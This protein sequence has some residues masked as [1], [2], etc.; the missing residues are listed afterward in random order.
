MAA[1]RCF[2]A[3][4]QVVKEFCYET[5]CEIYEGCSLRRQHY[6]V[7][8]SIALY[9]ATFYFTGACVKGYCW[10]ECRK[11]SILRAG[12]NNYYGQRFG[13]A[14][15]RWDTSVHW[16]HD[17]FILFACDQFSNRN[18]DGWKFQWLVSLAAR[19]AVGHVQRVR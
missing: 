15:A 2:L 14:G 6:V 19:D 12:R 16:L 7:P 1:F 4:K 13:L 11:Q 17:G 9:R 8:C 10:R 5:Q 3:L 18:T